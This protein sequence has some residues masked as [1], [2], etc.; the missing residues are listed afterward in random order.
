MADIVN[1]LVAAYC[2]VVA[3]SGRS[4]QAK[5]MALKRFSLTITTYLS[6]QSVTEAEPDVGIIWAVPARPFARRA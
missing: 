5:S 4:D 3:K 6:N 1:N 2:P